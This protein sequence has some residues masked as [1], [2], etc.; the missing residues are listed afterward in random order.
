MQ[1]NKIF[2][3][4]LKKAEEDFGFARTS[5]KQTRYYAQICFHFHQA[6]EKYLKA[7]IIANRL[8][9]RP[10][11]NLIKLLNICKNKNQR[12]EELEEACQYLNPFYIDTRYPVHWPTQYDRKTALNAMRSAKKVRDWIKIALR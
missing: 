1:K 2:R 12:T 9:F 6:A 4:W 10:I 8:E 7:F 11:H 5:L 3:E